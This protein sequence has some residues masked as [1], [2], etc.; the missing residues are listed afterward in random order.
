VLIG[1]ERECARL[2]KLLAD[3]RNGHSRALVLR[4]DPGIGKTALLEFAIERATGFRVLR[5]V[6]IESE[7]RLAFSGLHQLL[8][9]ALD[10]LDRVPEAAAEALSRSLALAAPSEVNPFL[11][12]AGA[13]HLLAAVAER[14]PV[15]AV[16][17][18]AH[19]LDPASAE[20]IAFTARRLEAESV[21]VLFAVR[22][23]EPTRLDTRGIP[24]LRVEGLSADAAHELLTGANG[25]P[26]A[27]G[28]AGRLV[29]A[30][31]GNPLA[32]LELPPTLS[33][34]QR[35]GKESLDDPIAVG[36]SVERAFLS[37]ARSLSP[38][39][40]DALLIAAAS[41]TGDLA[42]I[43]R[44]CG[45][46]AAALDEAEAAGLIHTRGGD[47]SFRHP[48]VRS[49]VYS[50]ATAGARREAHLAL[51]EA[52]GTEDADRRAWHLGAAAVGPDDEIAAALEEAADR[53]RDRGGAGAEARLVQRSA[54]LTRDPGLRATRLARAGWAALSAGWLDE[55]LALLRQG[56]ELGQDPLT[57]ADLYDALGYVSWSLGS[58]DERHEETFLAEADSVREADPLRAA[59]LLW[60]ASS[61]RALRLEVDGHRQVAERI[62]SVVEGGDGEQIEIGLVARAWQ[63]IFQS[64]L[65]EGIDLA[66]RG[67]ALVDMHPQR[68]DGGEGWLLD[69]VD[70]LVTLEQHGTASR[71]L[72]RA[73]PRY[74]A[75]GLFVELVTALELL[76]ELELNTGRL[77]RATVAATEALELARE[78]DLS[79]HL[80]W[81][82]VCSAQVEAVLGRGDDCRA[83]SAEA[84]ES[85]APGDAVIE[86]YA[87]DALGRLE[88]GA[89]RAA[90][91]IPRFERVREFA[92]SA[93]GGTP[94]LRWRPDLIEAY[95]RA[96]RLPEAAAELAAFGKFEATGLGPWAAATLA[97]SRAL[98]ADEGVVDDA[99]AEALRLC[100][101]T[102]SPF[103]RARTQLLYGERLRRAGRRL[104]SRAELRAA[105]EEFERLG[106]SSW[107]ERARE[108]LRASGETVRKRDPAL[109]DELTPRELEIALQ[110]ADGGT[111]KEVAAR[112]FLSPRT[113]ELHLGRVYRKLGIRSR[114]ELARLMP[115]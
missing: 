90:D 113:V 100:T 80:A 54:T 44:A 76:S 58:F 8:R 88:L 5:A 24:D 59:R 99:F 66:R 75:E 95:V 30:T 29:A 112:L 51:A 110:V 52:F 108:E 47:L 50:A 19:W 91:S 33:D 115:R 32:L 49:A 77:E 57:R 109:V 35:S 4:G 45:G 106:T 103:E 92:G 31:E 53:A 105:L 34:A 86:A 69:W 60:H 6:G 41:D 96:K 97:R 18:D 79:Q 25:D 71:L 7:S 63:A 3:V 26:I 11:A 37:R 68:R 27:A 98:L 73:I 20:A 17:D 93:A 55:A 85:R 70:I 94:Y 12:Y 83:H 87:F 43:A 102:V 42:A 64:E 107:A 16:L 67:A 62:W 74:R 114:T 46:N 104:D 101:D 78:L 2:V 9:P 56:L 82:L 111:N 38:E 15:I 61:G 48:L 28:V 84:V 10:A 13:L 39:A 14:E 89:G 72:E 21:A 81:A 65:A 40:G 1:R 23:G 22:E 36:E